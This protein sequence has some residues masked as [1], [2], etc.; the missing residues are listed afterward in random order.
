MNI[1]GGEGF[2]GQSGPRGPRGLPGADGKKGEAGTS[3]ITDL[4]N[5]LPRTMLHNFRLDSEDCCLLIW[6]D[7]DGGKE[8]SKDVK[9]DKDGKIS[10][11]I[12]RSLTPI[13]GCKTGFKRKAQILE[14]TEK[15]SPPQFLEDVGY[16][17]FEHSI[18]KVSSATLTDTYSCLCTTFKVEGKDLDQYIVSNWEK[19]PELP[20]TVRGIAASQKE[21]RIMGGCSNDADDEI[22]AN[23][24]Y[25]SIA[26]D[27]TDWTTI[28]V[29]WT[30]ASNKHRGTY[31]INNGQ[32]I[33]S[34]TAKES[35]ETL[36]DEAYIGGR[37]DLTHF[38]SGCISS[39]EWYSTNN[40]A[41]E[42]QLIPDRIKTLM[43]DD[44][45]VED[46]AGALPHSKRMKVEI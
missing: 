3:G 24:D 30:G 26:C 32:K 17:M 1:F 44:Q 12:S 28:F 40:E 27:T 5:W 9:T 15:C 14:K 11:W 4:F 34:F 20:H 41:L 22:A 8:S 19:D 23:K 35:G 29:E 33:G 25:V 21:I 13:Y 43:I 6:K 18:Y 36:S 46:D 10:E 37:A 42:K 16:L 7:A 31:N 45:I 39:V 2:R 38:F